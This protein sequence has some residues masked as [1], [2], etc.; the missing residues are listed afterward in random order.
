VQRERGV[1]LRDGEQSLVQHQGRAAFLAFRHAFFRRLEHEQHLA[2]QPVP[3]PD[4][5]LGD[6]HQHGGMRIMSAGVHHS[7]SAATEL[8]RGSGPEWHVG[9]FCDRQGIHVCPQEDSRARQ[10]AFDDGHHARVSHA[11]ADIEAQAA[12]VLGDF[13]RGARLAVGELGVAMKIP[14]PLDDALPE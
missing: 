6:A 4:E 10:A 9:A 12:K 11:R 3:Q 5:D 13:R 7:D 2:G 14:A 8:A 1:G